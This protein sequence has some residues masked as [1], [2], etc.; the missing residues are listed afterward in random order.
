MGL[1]D[2]DYVKGDWNAICDICG[3]EYK[4]SKLKENW[5]GQRVCEK[6]FETKH[7]QM[8]VRPKQEKGSSDWA[9]PPGSTEVW[10]VA[11][12]LGPLVAT[13]VFSDLRSTSVDATAGNMTLTLPTASTR[14]IYG[15]RYQVVRVDTSANTVTVNG[16]SVGPNQTIEFITNNGTSWSLFG[17]VG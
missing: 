4:A 11:D 17:R 5:K 7:P 9:R 15:N 16:L 3:F 6:D 1:W 10:T 13:I 8:F 14:F 2:S 12:L